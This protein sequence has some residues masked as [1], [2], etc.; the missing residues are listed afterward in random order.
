[1]ASALP[2]CSTVVALAVDDGKRK[3]PAHAARVP[4]RRAEYMYAGHRLHTVCARCHANVRLLFLHTQCQCQY[5]KGEWVAVNEVHD[6]QQGR[7]PATTMVHETVNVLHAPM[8]VV[9]HAPRS[10]TASRHLVVLYPI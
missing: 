6:V 7:S 1:M 2:C 4:R 10:S 8:L 3:G 5:F 9:V